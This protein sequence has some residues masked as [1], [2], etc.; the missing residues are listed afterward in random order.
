MVAGMGGLIGVACR[1]AWG[2][3]RYAWGACGHGG[4]P[5]VHVELDFADVVPVLHIS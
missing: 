3:G 2:R 1:V 5:A 4:L